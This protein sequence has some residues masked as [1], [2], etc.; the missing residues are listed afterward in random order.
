MDD[1]SRQGLI[2]EE[3][4]RVLARRREGAKDEIRDELG[5]ST[6]DDGETVAALERELQT[7]ECRA[8]AARVNALLAEDFEEIGASG[9]V[10]SRDEILALCTSESTDDAPIEV[11]DLRADR[12]SE[13]LILVQWESRRGDR[14]ALRTS[15]WCRE[16]TQWRLRHHQGTLIH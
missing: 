13:D 6:S 3:E 4:S 8:D 5:H 9:R 14:R 15:L 7:A 11:I 16:S 10:W 2:S 12:L 1:P